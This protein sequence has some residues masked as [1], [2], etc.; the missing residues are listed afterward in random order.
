MV[1]VAVYV[2]LFL[3]SSGCIAVDKRFWWKIRL[4]KRVSAEVSADVTIRVRPDSL[5]ILAYVPC[6]LVSYVDLTALIVGEQIPRLILYY[7]PARDH[8]PLGIVH[9]A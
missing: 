5:A 2:P 8:R 7:Y 3:W 1:S 4:G 6:F 9:R